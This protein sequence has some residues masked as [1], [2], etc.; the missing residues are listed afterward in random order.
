MPPTDNPPDLHELEAISRDY[1]RHRETRGWMT[2][3]IG[4]CMGSFG[5]GI[6]DC[7]RSYARNGIPSVGLISLLLFVFAA[8]AFVTALRVVRTR[9]S[10]DES[11]RKS[12][13]FRLIVAVSFASLPTILALT[14]FAVAMR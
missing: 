7:V 10:L 4:L 3:A 9:S 6:L 13:R 8:S 14:G 1:S 2:E 5:I 11:K 12:A